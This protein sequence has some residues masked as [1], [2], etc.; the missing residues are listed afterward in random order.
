MEEQGRDPLRGDPSGCA[1]RMT[2]GEESFAAL[3][4]TEG[5]AASR[6]SFG[7]RPQDDNEGEESFADVQDDS[8]GASRGS[9]A[10][11]RM[12]DAPEKPKRKLG[13]K[14]P[15][16]IAVVILVVGAGIVAY[17]TVSDW[18]N[19]YHQTRAIAT[20]VAA[21]QE[22]DP[23]VLE[24]MLE[25]A[26]EYNTRLVY[27][28]N[29]YIMNDAEKEEYNSLLNLTGDGIMGYV[30]VNSVGISYPIYHGMDE[31]V[32]QIAIGHLEGSSLPVG[33]LTTHA[34]ISG[35]RGLPS[36]KLFTDLDRV[37]EG[38]TFTVTVLNQTIA[39]E[40][41]QIRIVLPEELSNLE[42]EAGQDYCTLVTCTPYGVNTHR[43][44]VRGHRVDGLGDIEAVTADAVQIPRYIAIPAVA[45]P[46]MFL[47]LLGW[48]VSYKVRRPVMNKEQVI[49]EVRE[50]AR[51]RDNGDRS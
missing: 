17:P 1:L 27:K 39:Y 31:A 50:V 19:S 51:Q 11:L 29:R 12:T 8:V 35:H 48:L 47:F 15:T 41:D 6:G 18:W 20:Y 32:L 9:F 22:T 4:M 16:V 38:D 49:N 26:H 40:V 10:A 14:A 36:A 37:T 28:P 2:E 21:V 25:D 5:E 43:L 34:V 44:L 45:I 24:K 7:L 46:I 23:A 13:S 33:G 42:I 3:R 30:Q